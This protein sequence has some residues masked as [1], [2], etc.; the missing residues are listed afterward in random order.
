L[1][2]LQDEDAFSNSSNDHSFDEPGCS[3]GDGSPA[4]SGLV[5]PLSDISI[6]SGSVN[7]LDDGVLRRTTSLH[8][9]KYL[10]LPPVARHGQSR[11]D[12]GH[13]LKE[14][15]HRRTLSG[16]PAAGAFRS[17]D[18]DIAYRNMNGLYGTPPS[19]VPSVPTPY[20]SEFVA[21]FNALNHG[22]PYLDATPA[23]A[24]YVAIS[25]AKSALPYLGAH[26]SGV[27]SMQA[28]GSSIYGGAGATNSLNAV[29]RFAPI[30]NTPTLNGAISLPHSYYWDG[31]QQ[32]SY[33]NAAML[34]QNSG[35]QSTYATSTTPQPGSYSHQPT[36]QYIDHS[37]MT[38][39]GTM[40][41]VSPYD[42]ISGPPDLHI[43]PS[44]PK[45]S[46][47]QIYANPH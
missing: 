38:P 5:V 41:N 23:P 36:Y 1:I 33:A 40:G 13:D 3:S 2:R 14:K 21:P 26:T 19:I 39:N 12:T 22:Q 4:I 35:M 10:Q 44:S 6:A 28:G 27:N 18:K 29:G 25:S 30:Y 32:V 15:H 20:G 37:T 42:F 17:A 11:S 45:S 31:A 16:P 24:T 43:T 47:N 7:S 46:Y 9:Q 34:A 8:R